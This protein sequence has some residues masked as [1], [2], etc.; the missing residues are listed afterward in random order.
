MRLFRR[1]KSNGEWVWWASWTQGGA[2]VRRS[3]RCST[4]SAAELVV[5]RWERERAD[6]VY[7]ASQAATFGA[8]SRL[9][10]KACEGAVARGKMAAGTLVMYRQKVGTLTRI[11]GPDLRLASIDGATFAS[12]LEQ[13]RA[14]FLEDR[15]RPITESNLYKEWVAFRQVLKQAWRAERFARDPASLK[16][17]HFGPEYKPRETALTWEQAHNLL[18]SLPEHRKGA[19]AFALGCGARRREV[20]AARPGDINLKGKLVRI[21][22]TKTEHADATLPIVK[23]MRVWMAVAET[24]GLPFPA[25]GN[26]RRDLAMACEEL[27]IPAVTW[28]DLRRTFAS[29]L[30]Q[31]GVAPHLVA[32][33]LRHTTT[34][35]VDRVYGRQTAESLS[36]LIDKQL[37]REPTVNQKRPTKAAPK[38]DRAT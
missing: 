11:L 31:S 3:T 20:F 29:L 8:E 15:E 32:K 12:Y 35:M 16:P 28:N 22:G 2:T 13:R 19:V 7:A 5:A 38:R 14:E 18:A 4:K 36:D 24:A 37:R 33:L 27:G 21:R 23:P 30:V 9:F 6:P 10:L 25:W 17:P 34:A 26:A 1:R